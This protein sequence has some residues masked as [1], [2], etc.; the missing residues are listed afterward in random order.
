MISWRR[1]SKRPYS[2]E[3]YFTPPAAVFSKSEPS[4]YGT[5]GASCVPHRTA[6]FRFD[7]G[8]QHLADRFDDRSAFET[9]PIRN[10]LSARLSFFARNLLTKRNVHIVGV[11]FVRRFEDGRAR[12]LTDPLVALEGTTARDKNYCEKSN[13]EGNHFHRAK[14]ERPGF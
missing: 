13:Y 6:P 10:Y 9:D 8:D 5:R 14:L 1:E 2:Y 4:I 7:C 3:K 12:L 11:A